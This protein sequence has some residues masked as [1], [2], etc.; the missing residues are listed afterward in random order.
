MLTKEE[1]LER[2]RDLEVF[3]IGDMFAKYVPLN[4]EEK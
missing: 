3:H 4:K 2:N 1:I